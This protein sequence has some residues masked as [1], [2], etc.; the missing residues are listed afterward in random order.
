MSSQISGQGLDTFVQGFLTGGV[1]GPVQTTI[2]KWFENVS[3]RMK[4]YRDPGS[5]N[6]YI[7][8]E[9]KR[10][11][12]YAD[13]V[14]SYTQDPVLWSRWIS[15]NAIQQRDFQEKMNLAEE[16]GDRAAAETAKD[17]ALFMHVDTLLRAGKFDEFIDHLEGLTTMTDD[18]LKE[19][20]ENYN[21]DS[22]DQNE[23]SYRE[24][25]EIAVK[26]AKEIKGRVDEANKIENPFNPDLFD[27]KVDAEAYIAEYMAYDT[28]E[29][30]KRAI[31]F[32]EYTYK[33]TADRI[34]SLV[35]KSVT[36]G[37][38]GSMLASD[39]SILFSPVGLNAETS[40]GKWYQYEQLLQ[41]EIKSLKAGTKEEQRLGE[42]KTQ[43]LEKLRTLKEFIV[44]YRKTKVLAN[45]AKAAAQD[46]ASAPK[47]SQEAYDALKKLATALNSSSKNG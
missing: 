2:M 37:P 6:K 11:Q 20:F 10:L 45:K 5:R 15:E 40:K 19:A 38:L 14:N 23:K 4:D 29:I 33:R 42:Y 1:V 30:A 36:S 28:F 46:Y 35:N 21:V 44:Q 7:E 47:E 32:N 39:F 3:I 27:P 13:A 25:L 18:E 26:K 16:V 41:A 24:R 34:Q 22:T 43:Q 8:D 31:A 17:D 12:E 9:K